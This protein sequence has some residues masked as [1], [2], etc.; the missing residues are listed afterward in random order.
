ML[1]T[2]SIVTIL[3]I[4]LFVIYVLKN[5]H[6]SKKQLSHTPLKMPNPFDSL[7]TEAAKKEHMEN[8]LVE[9]GFE[10]DSY[11]DNSQI[12]LNSKLSADLLGTLLKQNPRMIG[13]SIRLKHGMSFRD[14]INLRRIQYIE[15]TFLSTNEYR[16]YSLDYIGERAGFGTRQ[17]FYIALKKLKNCTPKE[18]FEQIGE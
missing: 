4:Y 17:G 1:I 5:L 9:L 7:W 13:A 12:F 11:F 3:F 8:K 18:Y 6:R 16:K 10:I 2:F 15:E 14:Y